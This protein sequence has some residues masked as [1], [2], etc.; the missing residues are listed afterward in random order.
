MPLRKFNLNRY[1][2]RIF[3]MAVLVAFLSA[4]AGVAF[5]KITQARKAPPHATLIVLPEPRVI[6]DFVLIDHDSEPFSLDQLRGQWSLIFFGFTHC[7]DVCP[8]AL[9]ELQQVRK[10]L[11]EK[12]DE[13]T[14]VPQVLF[15]SVDPERDTP[16]AL[17]AYLSH[18][19]PSFIG[20]TGEHQQ[21]LPLT[22]QVGIAYRIED[23]EDGAEQY[24]VDHSTGILLTDPTGR[25]HGVFPAPHDASHISRDLIRA[26]ETADAG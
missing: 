26:L 3:V 4:T 12:A 14:T 18:F 15:V 1:N 17:Q 22:K 19:D 23:H 21:L 20:V 2:L 10:A 7:P 5:W 9:Y 6:A 25:L 13:S 24:N 11:E 8:T 16:K